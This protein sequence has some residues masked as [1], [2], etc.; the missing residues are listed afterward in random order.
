[1]CLKN[2]TQKLS[3]LV[4]CVETMV[5]KNTQT[6]CRS[7]EQLHKRFN[8]SLKR[9]KT[10]QSVMN[11]YWRHKRDHEN[12]LKKHLKEEMQEIKQIKEKIDRK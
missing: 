1:M 3:I 7:V 4:V 11:A 8:A 9:A 2:Y 10:R 5:T 6:Y 12:L